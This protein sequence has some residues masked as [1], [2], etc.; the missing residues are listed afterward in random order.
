MSA[1]T[2]PARRQLIQSALALGIAGALPKAFAIENDSVRDGR[3]IVVFLRGALDGLFP[4]APVA[5]PRLANLRPGLSREVLNLCGQTIRI[6][7]S[8]RCE[9]LNAA[10][11]AAVL[12][13]ESWR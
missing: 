11:A 12:L 7:M 5:D 2:S 3:L 1:L 4:F 8:D 9:S 6:P 13:W 10:I